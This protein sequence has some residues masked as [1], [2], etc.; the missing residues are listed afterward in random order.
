MSNVS[1]LGVRPKVE[2]PTSRPTL[3][4]DEN[5]NHPIYNNPN[6]ANIAKQANRLSE[7]TE[8]N[9]AFYAEENF[10]R[11]CRI[12]CP[13][14]TLTNWQSGIA[15]PTKILKSE[16][17]SFDFEKGPVGKTEKFCEKTEQ[18]QDLLA[19]QWSK[20]CILA[21]FQIGSY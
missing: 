9:D 12:A 5:S 6:N 11:L 14:R 7:M 20:V 10:T 15:S 19:D 3:V 1:K 8:E 16:K 17:T 2:D 13:A 4:A 21:I 18:I